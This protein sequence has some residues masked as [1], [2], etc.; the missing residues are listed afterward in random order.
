MTCHRPTTGTLLGATAL[1]IA[2]A[3]ATG[4]AAE[5]AKL[6]PGKL[7]K[8]NSITGKQVKDG[9]LTADDLVPGTIPAGTAGP[10]GPAGT[11]GP[12]G[13]QGPAGDPAS[14]IKG[15]HVVST[16]SA[17]VANNERMDAVA[18][19]PR[20]ER[21]LGG[22][23]EWWA[24]GEST[25]GASKPMTAYYNEDGVMAGMSWPTA[26]ADMWSAYG[27]NHSGY[28]EKLRVYVICVPGP[29]Q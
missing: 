8:P 6:I 25:I 12:A 15:Y 7:I 29:A 11:A 1:V 4:G 18:V 28:A 23:A 19:C 16:S 9:S 22:G 14:A 3:S 5:A 26:Y 27:T 17:A 2:L 10:A 13:P 20:G 21:A 24:G